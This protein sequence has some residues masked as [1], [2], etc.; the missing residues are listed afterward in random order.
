MFKPNIFSGPENKQQSSPAQALEDMPPYEEHMKS[1]ASESA[2]DTHDSAYVQGADDEP[3]VWKR[4]I[5]R[6]RYEVA[7]DIAERLGV[8]AG[9]L[10]NPMGMSMIEDHIGKMEYHSTDLFKKERET[11][12][13]VVEP[14]KGT[15][16]L[17]E[18]E[19]A[20]VLEHI[21]DSKFFRPEDAAKEAYWQ[22]RSRPEHAYGIATEDNGAVRLNHF[23]MHYKPEKGSGYFGYEETI[24]PT[25]D[26]GIRCKMTD[27]EMS[28][29]YSR[30]N[31]DSELEYNAD[32][33][34][35]RDTY[36]R[37]G[38]DGSIERR[39][40]LERDSENPFI[41]KQT[42]YEGEERE[43]KAESYGIVC[44][45]HAE[46]LGALEP[47]D[48]GKFTRDYGMFGSSWD[49]SLE[50]ASREEADQYYREH[51]SRQ[52]FKTGSFGLSEDLLLEDAQQKG[53][54]KLASQMD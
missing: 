6:A 4:N 37:Y 35:M 51:F 45:K 5:E 23:N 29:G 20:A 52:D 17:N 49:D 18:G 15:R 21:Q 12:L 19:R 44:K 33:V 43:P 26:G 41:S 27:Y 47:K 1:M 31:S 30:A 38:E 11:D 22:G 3:G 40:I 46:S 50:F 7:R 8:G 14:R 28:G 54:E 24:T 16:P 42:I 53:L 34:L 39:T 10:D 36:I 2:D 13:I 32:G 9:V 25:Q 48:R